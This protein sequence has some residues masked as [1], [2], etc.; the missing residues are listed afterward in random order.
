[1]PIFDGNE[2]AGPVGIGDLP[3]SPGVYL[4]TTEASGGIK[5]LGIYGSDSSIASSAESNPKKACWERN[6]K[7]S[8]PAF[9]YLISS[10]AAARERICRN[11]I[12]RRFYEVVCNDPPRD[13]F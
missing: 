12:D 5:I 9:Y 13:D 6:R 2:Y 8:D 1:M 3:D 7:D 10:D 11:M 4:V